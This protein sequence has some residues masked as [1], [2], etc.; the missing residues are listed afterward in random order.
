MISNV[1]ASSVASAYMNNATTKNK[2]QSGNV[3]TENAKELNNKVEKLKEMVAS[4]EY[5][6]DLLATAEKMADTLL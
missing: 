6:V 4:G 2:V 3:G 1:N 5:K